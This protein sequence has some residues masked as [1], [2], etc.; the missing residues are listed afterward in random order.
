[1]SRESKKTVD[2][3]LAQLETYRQSLRAGLSFAL[4][5]SIVSVLFFGALCAKSNNLKDTVPILFFIIIGYLGISAHITTKYTKKL[6]EKFLPELIKT[7]WNGS[8]YNPAKGLL[9]HQ[10]E[11]AKLFLYP[12]ES[13][14]SRKLIQ[15]RIGLYIAETM[16]AYLV[17]GPKGQDMEVKIFEG[18][19]L[20][21][22]FNKDTKGRTYVLPDKA[23]RWFGRPG[24][25]L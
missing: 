13:F 10:F 3:N 5:L 12:V 11:S 21:A 6:E 18:L 7:L 15:T 17:M 1:M 20:I 24:Q 14:R 19:F 25:T 9:Q 4:F 16:A 2:R 23:E 8:K 22:E